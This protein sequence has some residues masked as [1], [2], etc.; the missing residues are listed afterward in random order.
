MENQLDI[1]LEYSQRS[2]Y[3]LEKTR[4]L[5]PQRGS[6]KRRDRKPLIVCGHGAR[7]QI[8]RGTLFVRNGYTHYPQEREEFRFF[9]GDPH[10]PGR[11]I[12][13]DASGSISLD[14]L[15]WL[16]ERNIP[17]IQ[18]DWQ[19]NVI[20]VANM[21]YSANPK[22]VQRQL[23]MGNSQIEFRKLLTLKFKNSI[24][25]LKMFSEKY[26]AQIAIDFLR[27]S[28]TKL[29][30]PKL[31]STHELLGLEGSSAAKYFEAWQRIPIHWKL[32]QRDLI[33]V[34]W[35]YIGARRSTIARGNVN[36]R[37]PFNAMLNY[38]YAVLHSQIKLQIIAQGFDP[39]IGIFHRKQ[40]YRDAFVLDRME[41]FRPIVDGQILK[42]IFRETYSVND[43]ATT[44]DGYCRLNSQLARRIV[45]NVMEKISP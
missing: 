6:P 5:S 1:G 13:F 18:I 20:C 11:I 27:H 15:R 26:E 14:V 2:E 38:A 21:N 31:L 7:M 25:T 28:L 22:L 17:L 30:S 10:L 32:R 34:E 36:A 41:P 23:E 19:G 16:G 12:I 39:T 33:P 8:D 35:N 45:Q 3:W 44:H 37:H 9:R 4:E 29:K 24:L 40:Q 43:F 42:M